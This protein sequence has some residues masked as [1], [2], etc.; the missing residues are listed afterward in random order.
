M[1]CSRSYNCAS[2]CSSVAIFL[3]IFFLIKVLLAVF[4][5][6]FSCPFGSPR[7]D[8]QRIFV[9]RLCHLNAECILVAVITENSFRSFYADRRTACSL[10]LWLTISV[11]NSSPDNDDAWE[12]NSISSAFALPE[13]GATKVLLV[14]HEKRHDLDR[15]R[16]GKIP[17]RYAF[18]QENTKG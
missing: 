17:K 7:T 3:S 13:R 18:S 15:E 2:R 16:T 4:V 5:S 9:P 6:H 1:H 10:P 12:S 11:C 14:P 8:V